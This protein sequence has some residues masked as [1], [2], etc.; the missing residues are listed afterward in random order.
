MDAFSRSERRERKRRGVSATSADP[1]TRASV[2]EETN[3]VTASTVMPSRDESRKY[4][5]TENATTNAA[6]KVV[7][8]KM[9]S[10]DMGSGQARL[11]LLVTSNRKC[12]HEQVGVE[13]TQV[14]S[15]DGWWVIARHVANRSTFKTAKLKA[16]NP[17]SRVGVDHR[18]DEH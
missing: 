18:Q 4:V 8:K 15:R 3:T 10:R 2:G 11:L 14:T 13:H 9:A 17:L 7:D 5:A 1:A 16:S 6:Y 12:G